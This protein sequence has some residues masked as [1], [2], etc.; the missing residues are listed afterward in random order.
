[1]NMDDDDAVQVWFCLPPVKLEKP[2]MLPPE[3]DELKEQQEKDLK[4]GIKWQKQGEKKTLIKGTSF[5]PPSKPPP[6]PPLP[7]PY[8]S[9]LS[10]KTYINGAESAKK[11]ESRGEEGERERIGKARI[12]GIAKHEEK[13]IERAIAELSRHKSTPARITP[14]I[15]D[16]FVEE[17]ECLSGNDDLFTIASMETQL[18]PPPLPKPR[19]SSLKGSSDAVKGGEGEALKKQSFL[20]SSADSSMRN[21]FFPSSPPSTSSTAVSQNLI[22]SGVANVVVAT[23]STASSPSSSPRCS[24][25]GLLSSS[26]PNFVPGTA[27]FADL[28]PTFEKQATPFVPIAGNH[29][30][31][32][33]SFSS[34]S[35]SSSSFFPLSSSC[36][37]PSALS[38]TPPLSSPPSYPAFPLQPFPSTSSTSSS[39]LESK[40]SKRTHLADIPVGS[41]FRVT[42][43]QILVQSQNEIGNNTTFS[44]PGGAMPSLRSI[45]SS[46]LSPN[47]RIVGRQC[48]ND[49]LYCVKHTKVTEKKANSTEESDWLVY[50]EEKWH[51]VGAPI[52]FQGKHAVL[53]A[54]SVHS[55]ASDASDSRINDVCKALFDI[56]TA[57]EDQTLYPYVVLLGG[58]SLKQ[59]QRKALANKLYGFGFVSNRLHWQG[60]SEQMDRSFI[61][62]LE[63]MWRMLYT[64]RQ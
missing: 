40:S 59:G 10:H 8:L 14:R 16:A 15:V 5:P 4:E 45:V 18:M 12:A 30:A 19:S 6:P 41:P 63:R 1:M 22:G 24:T 62:S 23:A 61:L 52:S 11:E 31:L 57:C 55:L 53:L 42:V 28:T 2:P 43:F 47:W 64:C 39:A 29:R 27:N 60:L 25:Y 20:R 3:N 49:V 32:S 7:P 44:A 34:S 37:P 35:P 58:K 51:T 9:V 50:L 38:T 13:Q 21:S 26:P 36:P 33:R 54:C 56:F 46:L 17:N 48:S